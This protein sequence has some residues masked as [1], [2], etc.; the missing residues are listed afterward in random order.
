MSIISSNHA[1]QLLEAIP[2]G[3][4]IPLIEK[5]NKILQ[6]YIEKRWEPSELNGGK[7]CEIVYTIIKGYIEG[8]FPSSPEKPRNMVDACNS[9]ERTS[10]SKSP[11][12]V[13]I[14]IPRMLIALYEIRNNR[15]VG[16]IGGDVDPNYMDSVCVLQM[17]KWIMAELIRIFHDV[18]I[19][20]AN[21]A[22]DTLVERTIPIVWEVDGKIRV[23]DTNLGMK[24]K[25]L[26]I[27]YYKIKS[28]P[29]SDIFS[30]VEYSN[31]SMFRRTVLRK[32]HKMKFIEYNEET[33]MI[34]ISPKGVEYIESKMTDALSENL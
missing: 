4:R 6:N 28:V 3:L 14:Q 26:L 11:R 16:H 10:A 1:G 15:G 25:T 5:Y 9:L 2:S 27:L 20:T 22:V 18:D 31:L 19:K 23:L 12:S 8:S 33:K 32:L 13:R 30:W 24:E 17:C 29:E 34:T 21:E 7:F